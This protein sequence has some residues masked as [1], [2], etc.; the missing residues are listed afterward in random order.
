MGC[1]ERPNSATMRVVVMAPFDRE[2]FG[3]RDRLEVEASTLLALVGKLDA[4]APGFAD[5]AEAR[6]AFAVDGVFTPDWTRSTADAAE[7]IL[8]PRV[9]GGHDGARR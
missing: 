1:F 8:L 6:V 3:G 2:F 4:L 5:L 9:S 7:V